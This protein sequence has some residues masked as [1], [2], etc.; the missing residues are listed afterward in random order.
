MA[1]DDDLLLKSGRRVEVCC[2]HL[3][4]GPNLIP[5]HGFDGDIGECGEKLSP[6]ELRELADIAIDRWTR[7]KAK[8]TETPGP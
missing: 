3:S 5:R 7:F 6:D 2:N 4:I 8:L 1:N